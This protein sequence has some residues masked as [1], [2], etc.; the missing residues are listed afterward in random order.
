MH[1]GPL[2]TDG[3]AA[4]SSSYMKGRRRGRRGNLADL[5]VASFGQASVPKLGAMS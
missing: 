3:R 2:A 4:T 1:E 5:W